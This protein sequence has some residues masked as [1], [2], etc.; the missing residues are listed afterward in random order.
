MGIAPHKSFGFDRPMD[1][2]L[3]QPCEQGGEDV[4]G[5]SLHKFQSFIIYTHMP[6]KNKSL[7]W[8]KKHASSQA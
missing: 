1:C 3:K 4:S 7:R 5:N 8:Q 6:Q 2:S